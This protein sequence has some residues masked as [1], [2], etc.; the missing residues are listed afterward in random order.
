MTRKLSFQGFFHLGWYSL[1]FSN[2]LAQV[3]KIL[4][5]FYETKKNIILAISKI[6]TIF[7]KKMIKIHADKQIKVI[8]WDHYLEKIYSF[9]YSQYLKKSLFG[10]LFQNSVYEN[11]RRGYWKSKMDKS[12]VVVGKMGF[13]ILFCPLLCLVNNKTWV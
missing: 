6:E 10:K 1:S 7:R 9:C 5:W 3:Q 13:I 2:N 11:V 8:L 4:M 12:L